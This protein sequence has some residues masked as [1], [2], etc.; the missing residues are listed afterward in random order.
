MALVSRTLF[1]ILFLASTVSAVGPPV[2]ETGLVDGVS[3][4][5]SVEADVD[6]GNR[7]VSDEGRGDMVAPDIP[8]F[9]FVLVFVL[10]VVAVV[11]MGS[12]PSDG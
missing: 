10:V 5:D 7:Q 3:G 2:D 12:R 11:F 4:N 1:C 9:V 6:S 8:Y